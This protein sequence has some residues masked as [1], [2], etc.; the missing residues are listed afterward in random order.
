MEAVAG[1]TSSTLF[2]PTVWLRSD[3]IIWNEKQGPHEHTAFE[4]GIDAEV[5][6]WVELLFRPGLKAWC[7][8]LITGPT[9]LLFIS[10]NY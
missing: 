2:T 3:H 4:G 10:F 1:H 6:R 8:K 9:F 7:V 5:L